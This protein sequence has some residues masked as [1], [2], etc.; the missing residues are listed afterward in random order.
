MNP[1][2]ARIPLALLVLVILSGCIALP[3]VPDGATNLNVMQEIGALRPD[4]AC[5]R[6]IVP[7]FDGRWISQNQDDYDRGP[8]YPEWW[9]NYLHE[10]D[11]K[12][13]ALF[14]QANDENATVNATVVY[15]AGACEGWY[16]QNATL[17]LGNN[18]LPGALPAPLYVSHDNFSL[19]PT[20]TL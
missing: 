12:D 5:H 11:T 3:E 16:I 6:W 4:P 1:N 17:L 8:F 2:R 7:W 20:S 18:S 9:F 13:L 15:Q 19:G 14:R 10:N